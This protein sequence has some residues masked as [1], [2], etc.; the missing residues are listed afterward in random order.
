MKCFVE[1]LDTANEEITRVGEAQT[2]EDGIAIAKDIIDKYLMR[3]SYY[4]S[5]ADA[6]YT[7][8]QES[9]PVPCIF[10][11]DGVSLSVHSF[12]HLDYALRQCLRLCKVDQASML[13]ITP[14]GRIVD[15]IKQT[16]LSLVPQP[17]FHF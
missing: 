13:L 17:D 15:N 3:Q 7:R 5:S 14:S 8:Y 12:D 1:Q 6:L 2:L 4:N 16:R 9:G 11:D 10:L